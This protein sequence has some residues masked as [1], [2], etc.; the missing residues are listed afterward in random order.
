MITLP[1]TLT[2]AGACALLSIWLARR[3]GTVRGS[4]K[5]SIGDGGDP[6]LLARMRAHANFAE[7]APFVLILLGLVELARGTHLWLWIVGV[8][9][10]F[11]RIAH[12]FGMDGQPRNML[13][14]SGMIVTALVLVG[15]GLYAIFIPYLGIE[16]PTDLY[17]ASPG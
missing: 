5:V 7:Y 11:A 4:A 2:I 17:A 13:R 12:A 1:V 14:A 3:V 9:F 16:P 10:V 8:A 15:L 6:A